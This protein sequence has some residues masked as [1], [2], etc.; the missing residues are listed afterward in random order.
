[1]FGDPTNGYYD[2]KVYSGYYSY[3]SV[4]AMNDSSIL[5]TVWTPKNDYVL[6]QYNMDL[7][8]IGRLDEGFGSYIRSGLTTGYIAAGG[9]EF[10]YFDENKNEKFTSKV[11]KNGTNDEISI[12]RVK[13]S[14][15]GGY[16]GMAVGWRHLNGNS[17]NVTYLFKTD[18]M[19]KIYNQPQFNEKEAA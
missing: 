11:F 9:E 5:A 14:K 4:C 3:R 15:D 19:G 12:V 1:I 6:Y 10:G 17:T 8:V 7:N 16:Y 2:Y 18:S 13:P